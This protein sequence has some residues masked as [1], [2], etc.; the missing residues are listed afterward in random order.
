MNFPDEKLG[1]SRVSAL[2]LLFVG[3]ALSPPLVIAGQKGEVEVAA[4][5]SKADAAAR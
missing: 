5:L 4:E 3:L 1:L 2:G